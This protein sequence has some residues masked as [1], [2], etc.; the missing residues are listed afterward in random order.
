MAFVRDFTFN[1]M[2]RIGDDSC[3]LTQ[4]NIQDMKTGNYMLT[5]YFA[6]DCTMKKSIQMA[7]NQPDVF[8]TGSH[9]V[10]VGGCNV[11]TNTDLTHNLLSRPACKISLMQRPFATVP[12]LGRGKGNPTMESQIQQGDMRLK[13]KSTD[14]TSEVS[15]VNY[16]Y[17]PLLPSIE[18]TI[19]NP[20]NL[21]EGVAAEGWIRGGMPARDLAKKADPTNSYQY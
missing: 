10:G 1:N 5:N 13:K 12:F 17:T 9:Q 11:D 18:A 15:H 4:Q 8:Y 3:S 20:A 21:V 16:S 19:N 14:P 6:D 2:A 7:T